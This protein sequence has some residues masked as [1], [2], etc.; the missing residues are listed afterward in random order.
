MKKIINEFRLICI[1]TILR[2]RFGNK[3]KLG[4]NFRVRSGFKMLIKRSG[5]VTIGDDVSFNNSCS[6]NALGDITIGNHVIFGEGVRLYDHNHRFK[7]ECGTF[8]EQ[9]MSIGSIV[10]GNNCWIGSNVVILKGT[11]ISDNCV[12]GAGCVVSGHIPEWT[13]I[14]SSGNYSKEA[15]VECREKVK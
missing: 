8:D 10:I 13:L 1:R 12:I 4:P 9:P 11:H 2:V 5:N 6:V 14:R 7:K 3:I 15:I